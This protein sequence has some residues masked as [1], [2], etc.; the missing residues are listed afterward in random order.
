MSSTELTY[1]P[2]TAATRAEPELRS[3]TDI[4]DALDRIAGDARVS[5]RDILD[6]MGVRSFAPILLVP[7]MI[8]VSPLS[9]IPGLP[10]L[11]ALFIFLLT[12]QKLVG[13]SR[14]WLPQFLLRRTVDGAKFGRAVTWLRKPAG[15]I[16]RRTHQRLSWM[17]RRPMSMVNMLVIMG[18][19]V[20]IP[21]LEVLP[22]V[23]SI[24]ATAIS[25]YAISMLA[26]DG[27]F[28][29]LGHIWSG[30]ALFGIWW[31]ISTGAGV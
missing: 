21:F 1:A 7:S 24:F 9:G 25:F 18:I 14:T 5:V 13:R 3:L 6:E 27:L 16:D 12:A 8:L 20:I 22:M 23:T 28:A 15:W 10:T 11:G 29:V 26:R 31:L 30:A 19:C 17:V 4:L 2:P